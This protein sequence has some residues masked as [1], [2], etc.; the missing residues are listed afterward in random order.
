M[1]ALETERIGVY[2]AKSQLSR[3]IAA[4]RQG[5]QVTITQRGKDVARLVPVDRGPE[6]V[7]REILARRDAAGDTLGGQLKQFKE[8]GRL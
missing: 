3:L 4:V 1:A 7:A 2:Q 5:R 6:D 8:E